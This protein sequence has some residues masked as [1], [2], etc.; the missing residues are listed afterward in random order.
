MAAI[1]APDV[2]PLHP[3][4][5]RPWFARPWTISVSPVGAFAVAA[6]LAGIL[7]LGTWRGGEATSQ[8]ALVPVANDGSVASSYVEQRQFILADSTARSVSIV[9]D[10]NDW[11][12]APMTRLG[13]GAWSITIPLRVGQYQFHYIVNDSVRVTDPTL[14]AVPSAFGSSN[15]FINVAIR[16]Q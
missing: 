12:P 3:A 16:G 11:E 13:D 7:A 6:G 8:L 2:I 14:P 5:R 15:S 9:G 10:F 1:E 4:V